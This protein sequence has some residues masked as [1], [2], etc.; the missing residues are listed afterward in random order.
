M[1]NLKNSR[2]IIEAVIANTNL[3]VSIKIRT[4]AG[5]VSAEEF[6]KNISDVSRNLSNLF[7]IKDLF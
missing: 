3:P 2:A 5:T 7:I 4:Q 6:L 1:K